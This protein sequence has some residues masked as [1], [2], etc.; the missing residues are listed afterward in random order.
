MNDAVL[1]ALLFA[2]DP[3]GTGGVWLRAPPGPARDAWLAL[4]R[5]ALPAAS[6]LRRMPACI[7]DASLLGGLDLA[8]SLRLGRRA[9]QPGL[10]AASDGGV[11]L[12]AMAERLPGATA[13]R[14]A[15]AHDTGEVVL[16]RE[17][18]AARSPARL[19]LVALDEGATPEELPPAALLD[20]LAF[21]L[22]LSDM[23]WRD[24]AL[25]PDAADLVAAARL[26]LADARAGDGVLEALCGTALALGIASL[27]APLLALRVA[28]A[29]AALAGRAEPTDEDAAAAARLVFARRATILPAPPPEHAPPPEPPPAGEPGQADAGEPRPDAALADILLAATAAALPPDLLGQLGLARTRS[30]G[31]AGRAGQAQRSAQRGRP[32]GTRNGQPGGGA[33]LHLLA[34]LSAA[35]PWQRLRGALPGRPAI[36]RDDFRTTVFSQRRGTTTIFAVD[37]SGSAALQRLAEAKGAIE[38]MLAECYVRRD[39]VALVAFRGAGAEL[40]LPP[41]NALARVRRDLAG[42]PGGGGTPLAAGIALATELAGTAVRAGQTPIVVLLTDGRANVGRD[43]VGGRAQAEADALAAAR[44]LRAAGLAALLVDTSAR[45]SPMAERLAGAAGARYLPLPFADATCLARAV[46]SIAP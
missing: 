44:Q 15:A 33:R 22:D 31:T 39:R 23:P 11:V 2:V 27:R 6:P 29:A 5:A 36:R 14:L 13:S 24:I 8:A 25:P 43:G 37:A 10:L 26:R 17:G 35:A 4:L 7:S 40:R 32:I 41:T 21:Q 30:G 9:A 46:R 20:R 38:L 16:E 3:A 34:T 42:L 45:P 12:L 28:R 18:V 1:S 19:G